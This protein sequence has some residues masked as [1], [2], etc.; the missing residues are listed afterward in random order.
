MPTKSP[1]LFLTHT[2]AT[3]RYVPAGMGEIANALKLQ[4]LMES[5]GLTV[6]KI[7]L[8]DLFG[9]PS[10]LYQTLAY[11]NYEL[12]ASGQALL[13]EVG[14]S[15][16]RAISERVKSFRPKALFLLSQQWSLA[17]VTATGL[18]RSFPLA[19]KLYVHHK[20]GEVSQELFRAPHL[21]ITESMLA[22]ELAARW[23]IERERL[24]Y[25]PHSFPEEVYTLK[26]DRSYIEQRALALGKKIA[27]SEKTLIVGTA[28][29]LVIGKNV[30]Y[31]FG[32]ARELA[33]KG[34][35]LLFVLKGSNA[36]GNDYEIWLNRLLEECQEEPWFLW[37][38]EPSNL[39][40]ML[41][42]YS[43]LDLALQLSGAEAA[44]NTIVELLSLGVPTV[45]L[46][47]STNPTLF[48]D[49]VHFV[50][51]DP[52]LVSVRISFFRPDMQDLY[53]QVERVALDEALRKDL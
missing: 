41:K 31:A 18:A 50:Q 23:G 49:G 8:F 25:L 42:F 21:L 36:A 48:S 52:E 12:A 9:P 26:K 14:Y 11:L 39:S 47:A 28:S 15:E 13:E 22:S 35:D 20:E 27:L 4:S 53:Q 38:K 30:E 5:E 37:D 19:A 44:S 45:A 3:R 43:S 34:V 24:F 16:V 32:A 1:F 7:D 29:R 10:E 17:A 6:E 51:K 33:R 46:E 2:E 40:G